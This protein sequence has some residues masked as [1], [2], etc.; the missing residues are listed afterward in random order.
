M[1]DGPGAVGVRRSL[2]SIAQFHPDQ[3]FGDD[4][5]DGAFG[6]TLAELSGYLDGWRA[7]KEAAAGG[8]DRGPAARGRDLHP[9]GRHRRPRAQ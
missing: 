1:S 8:Q 7:L 3:H 5:L 6:V 4:V 9:A 2:D